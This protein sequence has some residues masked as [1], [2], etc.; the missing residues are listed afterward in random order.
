MN[1]DKHKKT[2]L[3][4]GW[5]RCVLPDFARIV[6]GQSPDSKSYNQSGDGFPFFQGK[7]EFGELYPTIKIYC[8]KPKKI[9]NLG[10]TLLSVR[11]PVGP[12]NLAQSECCI[13]RGLAALH[14]C[15]GMEP[16][17]LLYALQE[18]RTSNVE[19]RNRYHINS[20]TKGFIENL[21]FDLPPLDEQ[22]RIVSPRLM[23]C[24]L[25]SIRA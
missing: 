17:F 12:T 4:C 10:A 22:R 6:M 15:G 18:Y 5:E 21:E 8:S 16:K 19:A 13:G 1:N 23:N 9:A 3:P 14:P 25:N 7:A 24:F 2:M 11:A 20:V